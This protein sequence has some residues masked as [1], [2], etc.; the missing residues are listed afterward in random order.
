MPSIITGAWITATLAAWPQL[1]AGLALAAGVGLA[2][3]FRAAFRAA[4]RAVDRFFGA[5]TASALQ[6]VARIIGLLVFWSVLIEALF[7][8]LRLL[9]IEPLTAVADTILAAGP[10]LL[11]GIAIIG[12]GHLLAASARAFVERLNARRRHALVDPRVAYAVV[13]AVAFLTGLDQLGLDLSVLTSF[14]LIASSAALAAVALAFAL[15]AR[16][17]AANLIAAGELGDYRPGDRVRIDGFEGTVAEIRPTRLVLITDEGRVSI[18]A[19]RFSES[20]SVR[21]ADET[22]E[23]G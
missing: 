8:A 14:V 4:T 23:R 1:A 10:R 12:V 15:G 3:L 18:P 13:V 20:P 2:F 9:G 7:V 6:P 19:A 16:R 5:E 21:L 22:D 17:H 11:A